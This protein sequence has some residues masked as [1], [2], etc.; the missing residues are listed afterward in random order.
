MNKEFPDERSN[1][2]WR[3]IYLGVIATTF[4]VVTALWAF[5]QYFK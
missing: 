4:V 1:E 2:F 3:K 5:S